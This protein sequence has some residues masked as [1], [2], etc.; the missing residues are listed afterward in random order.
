MATYYVYMI[1]SGLGNIYVGQA[2]DLRLRL[3]EHNDGRNQTTK[4]AADWQLVYFEKFDTRMMAVKRESFFKS[5]DGRR[6]LKS[7]IDNWTLRG[8]AQLGL[9]RLLGVQEIVGSNPT[10]PIFLKREGVRFE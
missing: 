5:G 9:E 8:V 2:E 4:F 7:K 3:K 6:V 1:R 10:A